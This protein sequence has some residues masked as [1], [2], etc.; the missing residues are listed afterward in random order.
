MVGLWGGLHL[1]GI[2]HALFYPSKLSN[3]DMGSWV[4]RRTIAVSEDVWAMLNELKLELGARTLN[5][6]ILKLL[7]RYFEVEFTEFV[8][9]AYGEADADRSK[10]LA[11]P[12]GD[13]WIK[14]KLLDIIS[15]SGCRV[16]VEVFGGSGVVSMYAP[17]DQFKVIVYNDI[18]GL[19]TNFFEVLRDR[20]RELRER[21]LKMP[22]SRR[23]VAK[24][25]EMIVSGEVE[26]LD[27]VEKA[28]V[29]FYVTSL[30]F[31]RKVVG[32]FSV[33][34]WRSKAVT[35]SRKLISLEEYARRWAGVS[36][37]NMDFRRVIPAYDTPNTVFYC[38]PPHL[39]VAGRERKDYYRFKFTEQ[40][41]RDLL[42]LLDGI[43]GKFVLRITSDNLE[44]DFIR[45]WITK[46]KVETVEHSLYMAK[47]K[48]EAR[49]RLTTLLIHN[50]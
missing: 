20:P 12:G 3:L 21:L 36:I 40:D 13:W 2:P 26:K 28:A 43:K 6:V 30:S 42:G 4:G 8:R 5:D 44:Y 46:Y 48:G 33:E 19:L 50:Y 18:D 38:D 49:S 32:G 27:P 23:E 1:C 15:R 7:E 29:W 10:P 11:F 25:A 45:E 17:R 24:Y 22:A 39:P 47:S 31:N 35:L 41:M 34:R 16:L 37:E 9:E 14:D